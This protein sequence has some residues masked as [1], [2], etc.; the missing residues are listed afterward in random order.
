[1]GITL[2]PPVG[3]RRIKPNGEVHMNFVERCLGGRVHEEDIEQFVEDWHRGR[4]G[5]GLELH[6][7][8]GMSWDEYQLWA[9]TPS[10]LSFVVA[11]KNTV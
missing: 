11:A 1:M 7:Y 2:K 4:E 3:G 10:V 9:S 6:E 8:L 5:A